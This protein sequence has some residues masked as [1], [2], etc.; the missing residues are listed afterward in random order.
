MSPCHVTETQDYSNMRGFVTSLDK[1]PSEGR[2]FA[3]DCEMVN[4]T[5]GSELCRV[6]M[7]DHTGNTCYETLVLPE[8]K[9]V[10]YNTRFSG[11]KEADLINNPDIDWTPRQNVT[12]TSVTQKPK[13]QTQ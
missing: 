3:M 11:I 1:G 10:D 8:K 4:T 2:V 13:H 5:V 7:I 6:T 12:V 9:I